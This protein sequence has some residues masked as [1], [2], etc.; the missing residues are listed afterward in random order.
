MTTTMTEMTPAEKRSL[1]LSM[2]KAKDSFLA[3]NTRYDGDV[4]LYHAFY[5]HWITSSSKAAWQKNVTVDESFKQEQW[6][7]IE[8]LLV[9]VRDTLIQKPA[10]R[11]S[12]K[13]LRRQ[14]KNKLGRNDLCSCGSNTKYKK[15]CLL[16]Q[17]V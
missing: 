12:K 1:T 9:D 5:E 16:Q 8:A 14:A 15:C 7:K 4:S 2:K 11:T 13:Q 17:T 3:L 6:S 10:R